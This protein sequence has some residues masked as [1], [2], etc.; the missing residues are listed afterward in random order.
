MT[1][2]VVTTFFGTLTPRAA[3]ALFLQ[4]KFPTGRTEVAPAG[5]DVSPSRSFPNPERPVPLAL[6]GGVG[7]V[8]LFLV[9]GW[10]VGF[11]PLQEFCPVPAGAMWLAGTM[12]PWAKVSFCFLPRTRSQEDMCSSYV[13][14]RT[15]SFWRHDMPSSTKV[16]T[17]SNFL[18]NLP[19]RSRF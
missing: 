19:K 6:L 3:A 2:R 14:K 16:V 11:F 15:P 12:R 18:F 4:G 10:W 9:G 1:S 17:A 5:S 7:W 8:V 13:M